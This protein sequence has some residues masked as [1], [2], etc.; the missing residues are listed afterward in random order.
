[1]I[2]IVEIEAYRCLKKTEVDKVTIG[3]KAWGLCQM[4]V[5]WTLPFFVISQEAYLNISKVI[6]CQKTYKKEIFRIL[7][8]VEAENLG[9]EIIIRSSG[10]KEGMEERGKY[11][12]TICNMSNLGDSLKE[13]IMYLNEDDEINKVGIPLVVQKYI[14][15][16]I[17]GHLSNER[18]V[19][20]EHRDFIYEFEVDE[21]GAIETGEIHLRNWRKKYDP[22]VPKS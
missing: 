14:K 7:K 11:E 9:N 10:L 5:A 18:R 17:S 1:M 16:D 4:P 8:M 21:I 20:K 19:S 2:R 6:D 13:L 3:Q 15:P 22:Y 12:S